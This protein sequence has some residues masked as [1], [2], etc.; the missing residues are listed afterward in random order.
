H[1]VPHPLTPSG[2]GR[3]SKEDD[4]ARVARWN[5]R[6]SD[7]IA[8]GLWVAAIG[9]FTAAAAIGPKSECVRA[10]FDAQVSASRVGGVLLFACALA[11]GAAAAF[12]AGGA[13]RGRRRHGKIVRSL[14]GL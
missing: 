2:L 10:N 14:A 3:A 6:R 8:I 1:W 12:L 4:I 11:I 7:W 9:F 5:V 13:I